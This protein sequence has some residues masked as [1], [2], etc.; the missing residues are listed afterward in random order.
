MT[1]LLVALIGACTSKPDR[2]EWLSV[3]I[4]STADSSHLDPASI[5]G[6]QRVKITGTINAKDFAKLRNITSLYYLDLSEATIVGPIV[7]A[8]PSAVRDSI[9]QIGNAIPAG[10]FG[11]FSLLRPGID[12]INLEAH[13]NIRSI[14][15]PPSLT[16]IGQ[17]A[18]GECG[19]NTQ[20]VIPEAVTRIYDSAF[21]SCGYLAG[22]IRLPGAMFVLGANAFAGCAN[23]TGA[24]AIPT[25]IDSISERLFTNCVGITQITMGANVRAIGEYAFAATS[26]TGVE[27]P[28]ALV[29]IKEGAFRNCRA[30][31]G[32]LE[33]PSRLRVIGAR[34]FE[35]AGY[36]QTL[37]IPVSVDSIGRSAF[38]SSH[39]DRIELKWDNLGSIPAWDSSKCWFPKRFETANQTPQYKIYVP[40]GALAAYQQHFTFKEKVFYNIAVK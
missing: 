20:I 12:T 35:S 27:W 21:N 14:I 28:E 37:T 11:R 8:Y 40:Q 24:V 7:V 22:E 36:D 4:G 38:D 18:F 16:A 26:I 10:A 13:K 30:L 29:H 15:F 34:A 19:L 1:V 31:R 32:S 17:S 5:A 33:L 6:R 9:I 2:T 39:F 23:V 25:L 3:Q